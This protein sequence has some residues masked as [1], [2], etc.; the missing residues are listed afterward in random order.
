MQVLVE[1]MPQKGPVHGGV[2]VQPAV[3]SA[4][5]QVPWLLQ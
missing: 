3:P 1:Q 5:L 2:Q 4:S